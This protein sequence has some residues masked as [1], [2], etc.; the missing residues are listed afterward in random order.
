MPE[1]AVHG[2]AVVPEHHVVVLPL[3]DVLEAWLQ[4]VREQFAY[5]R[6]ALVLRHAHDAADVQRAEIQHLAAGLGVRPHQRVRHGREVRVLVFPRREPRAARVVEAH[7]V[8]IREEVIHGLERCDACLRGGIEFVPRARGVDPARLPAVGGALDHPQQ[9]TC[10]RRGGEGEI[11][12]PRDAPVDVRAIE[13]VD[14]AG[15]AVFV[16]EQ[17]EFGIALEP[18]ARDGVHFQFAEA[19]AQREQRLGGIRHAAEE[20]DAVR[21]PRLAQG[22]RSGGV[23]QGCGGKAGDRDADVAGEGVC[24][25]THGRLLVSGPACVER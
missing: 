8:Q 3:V 10:V 20:H 18:E 2:A 22:G 11:R 13:V 4:R 17:D 14:R 9:R 15:G 23:L 7:I 24:G 12:V 16:G 21:D 5:Q 1:G 19:T 6:V 25:E